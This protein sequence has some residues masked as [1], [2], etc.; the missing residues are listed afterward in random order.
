MN[1]YGLGLILNFT[2]NASA[3][4]SSAINN[5]NRLSSVA[6]ELTSTFDNS[7][8]A[9]Y[10]VA[11]SMVQVGDTMT[12]IGSSITSTLFGIGK[13]VIDTGGEF[14]GYRMQ[15]N[16]LYGSAEAGEEMLNRLKQKAQ[17]SVF[18]VTGLLSSVTMMK[19]VG[20][21]ALNEV[22]TASG[23]TSQSILDYASDIAAMI[24]NMRNAYGTGVKAAM[25]A[26]KEYIAE[27]NAMSLKRGAGLDITGILGED[28]GATIEERTQQIAELVEQLGIAGYTASLFG[29]PMQII[30]NLSDY[31][32]N[33]LDSVSQAGVYD[34]FAEILSLIGE[35]IESLVTDTDRYNTIIESFSGIIV[36]FLDVGLNIISK[37]LD[38]A[39]KVVQ[40]V[41]DYPQIAKR[42]IVVVA[43]V[44]AFL[45][46]FGNIMKMS[47][48]LLMFSIAIKTLSG[49]VGVFKG[50]SAA[51]GGSLRVLFPLVLIGAAL[52]T[53]WNNNWFGIQDK[54]SS[55]FEKVKL[56]AAYF[57]QGE[58]FTVEQYNLAEKLGLLPVI[59]KL[60]KIKEKFKEV[61]D[62]IVDN[63]NTISKFILGFAAIKTGISVVSKLKSVFSVL[64]KVVGSIGEV[65][66][67][68]TFAIIQNPTVGIVMLI[69]A[70][71]VALALVIYKNWDKIKAILASVWGWLKS[72]I[73]I[74]VRNVVMTIV[75]FVVGLISTIWNAVSSFVSTVVTWVW[76]NLIQPVINFLT[77]I[78]T[79]VAGFIA[80]AIAWVV[81]LCV[82]IATWVY[83]NL[84][85]P[86][87]NFVSNLWSGIVSILSPIFSWVNT[88]IISPIV[89]AFSGFVSTISSTVQGVYSA[90]TGVF[91]KA[92]DTITGV[93]S[94]ITGFF[95]GI[96]N[97]IGGWVGKILNAGEKITGIKSKI[98]K[99]AK[100]VDNFVG[101]LIQ[102]NEEGG[103]LIN[104]PTGSTVIPHDE[105]VKESLTKGVSIGAQAMAKYATLSTANKP[106][107][108]PVGGNSYDYSVTFGSGS[109]VV[110]LASSS[111]IEL[112]K[113]ADK[114]MKIIERKQKLRSLAIRA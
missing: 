29:T 110:Q 38:I 83:T 37:I 82:T 23:N 55:L 101:G 76:D 103:E 54:V 15:L 44:G 35:F 87:V 8:V 109:V 74:P 36:D 50:L 92:Y 5:F 14:F 4:M 104:L 13:T 46:V 1:S 45:V 65:I 105:S 106:K 25:G 20:I 99:A 73:I 3:G 77:P 84:I 12:S 39:G 98:P 48:S 59:E 7:T 91:Q 24:P 30:S 69:V 42:I 112:E 86:V 68:I 100:G 97:S 32:Y 19:V 40:W 51:L 33:F 26:L 61:K 66:G 107:A 67:K 114:L 43:A 11:Q 93:W 17:S 47:G 70:A 6:D 71:V 85:T 58:F 49:G 64:K 95:S 41:A 56:V 27:G 2:D 62:A 102:V 94:G 52:Y 28:K 10:A 57:S 63:W 31:W 72:N 111:D 80:N 60:V 79:A 88:N 89:S 78:I 113:V 34:K 22:T 16:S 90:L 21:D 81:N 53:A 18:D 108:S 9:L 75:N 96:W